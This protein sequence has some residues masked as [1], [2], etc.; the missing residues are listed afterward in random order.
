[1]PRTLNDVSHDPSRASAMPGTIAS[2]SGTVGNAGLDISGA[3][4]TATGNGVDAWDPDVRVLRT[5]TSSVWTV[6]R[7]SEKWSGDGASTDARILRSAITYAT[8]R[9]VRV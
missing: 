1:M 7:V 9:T 5:T 3:P 6:P 4:G 8:W 2:A